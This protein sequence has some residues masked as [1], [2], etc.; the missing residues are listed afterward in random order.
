MSSTVAQLFAN[1]TSI[2]SPPKIHLHRI[3]NLLRNMLKT[4]DIEKI[5]S[6]TPGCSQKIHFNNAGSSLSPQSVTDAVISYLTREQE[7]GGYEAAEEAKYLL[8][9][10][11]VE[12]AELLNCDESEIAFIEN[13]TR[14]WELAVHSIKWAHGDQIIT[15]ETEYGSNYLGLLHIAKRKS[16]D[17]ITVPCDEFGVV[18]LN[19]LEKSI[20]SKTKLIAL[21]HIAS[22][23]GDIQPAPDVGAIAKKNKVLFLL[24][25]CQSVGQINLDTEELNCDFLCGSGRKYLRGPRGTGFLFVKN[26]ILQSLEPIFLDLHSASWRDSKSY[27]FINTAKMFE[28]YERNVAAM[29]G[30]STAVQYLSKLGIN[31]IEERI[32]HLSSALIA[33]LSE[34]Q[35]I[36]VLE[37]SHHRS[38]I[39]TFTK[40]NIDAKILRNELQRRNINVSV[41][42]QQNA[43]LDLGVELTGDV[44]RASL[45]YY[46]TQQEVSEFLQALGDIK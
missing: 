19:Q 31:A 29:I 21:T 23:R 17:L 10:F 41:C 13:S 38:G 33:G 11:Y 1:I 15:A 4:L 35:G 43:Q 12:F 46:N 5:R 18:S 20:T 26:K 39:I 27:E 37:K 45:H 36:R 25:A 40:D 2:K 3:L 16:L 24:D 32:S 22:Q 9:N 6:E 44:T 7:V 34:L 14:A 42:K 30:L 8:N 28:C